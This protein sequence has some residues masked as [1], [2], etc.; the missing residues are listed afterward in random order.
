MR[1]FLSGALG[2]IAVGVALIA[3]GV[4][5]P[6]P[7]TVDAASFAR[8]AAECVDAAPYGMPGAMRTSL[9]YPVAD[10]VPFRR[11]PTVQYA[12]AA[13]RRVTRVTR[14][15]D[16]AKTAMVIGGAGAAGAGV[17]ALLG[18]GKGAAIGAAIGGG[19]ATLFQVKH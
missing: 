4:F 6:R 10:S 2:V 1:T 5:N 11:V 7:A 3:Y 13:P 16:W 15:R 19:A 12:P 9:V 14:G 8:P 18:G 17:G